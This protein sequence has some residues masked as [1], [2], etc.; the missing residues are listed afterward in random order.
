MNWEEI[1]GKL[2][3]T[4]V[5]KNQTELAQFLLRVAIIADELNHHPDYV[6]F[7]CSFTCT[8]W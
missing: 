1:N 2:S 5:F 7:K 3:K 8:N 6:V 4:Y